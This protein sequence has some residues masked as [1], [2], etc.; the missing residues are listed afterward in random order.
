MDFSAKIVNFEKTDNKDP[1]ICDDILH[2]HYG[3]VK[4]NQGLYRLWN[5]GKTMEF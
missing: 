4:K 2:T 1:E 5:S 3:E